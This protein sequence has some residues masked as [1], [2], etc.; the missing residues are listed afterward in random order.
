MQ[1]QAHR[2][3]LGLL[4]CSRTGWG[5]AVAALQPTGGWLHIHSNVNCKHHS[6]REWAA[7]TAAEV[8]QI[9]CAQRPPWSQCI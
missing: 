9:T 2:V 4:P 7:D 1:E 5:T 8:A 3:L 6:P